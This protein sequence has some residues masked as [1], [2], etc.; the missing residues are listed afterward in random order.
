MADVEELFDLIPVGTPIRI[1]GKQDLRAHRV[2]DD[3]TQKEI[4][5]PTGR[6]R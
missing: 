6:N 5:L 1:E 4:A 3:P 2:I